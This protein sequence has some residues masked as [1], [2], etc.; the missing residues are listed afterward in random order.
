MNRLRTAVKV[1]ASYLVAGVIAYPLALAVSLPLSGA[2]SYLVFV[3]S[4]VA[5][6]WTLVL[7]ADLVLFGRRGGAS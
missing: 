5:I 2:A 1:A 7:A 6:M 3:A 4:L